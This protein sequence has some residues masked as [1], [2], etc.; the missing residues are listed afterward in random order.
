MSSWRAVNEI[1]I[2]GSPDLWHVLRVM[3][4]N[5]AW[6]AVIG[7]ALALLPAASAFAQAKK[8]PKNWGYEIVDG[9]RVPKADKRQVNADGSWREERKDGDCTEIKEKTSSGELKITRKCD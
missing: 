4:R 2:A 9:K 8:T 5:Y 7:T 6:I 3:K 1:F